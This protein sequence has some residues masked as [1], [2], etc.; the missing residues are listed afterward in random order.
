MGR[1]MKSLKEEQPPEVDKALDNIGSGLLLVFADL[2]NT[3]A[4]FPGHCIAF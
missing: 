2:I 3:N 4:L 1:S